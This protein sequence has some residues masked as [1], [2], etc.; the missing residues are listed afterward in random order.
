MRMMILGVACLLAY[1]NLQGN[2]FLRLFSTDVGDST[3]R[4]AGFL[5]MMREILHAWRESG[6]N[7]VQAGDSSQCGRVGSPDQGFQL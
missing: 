1:E 5:S 2:Y 7:S 6:R 4:L 3:C